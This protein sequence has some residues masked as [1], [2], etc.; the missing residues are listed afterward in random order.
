MKKLLTALVALA[1]VVAAA[2]TFAAEPA[3][4]PAGATT[5]G[6][7]KVAKKHAK[8]SAKKGAKTEKTDKTEKTE[9]TEPAPAPA[10]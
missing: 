3:P 2:P 4:D 5:T 1:F 7:P 9:K 8:K 10:R 6:K